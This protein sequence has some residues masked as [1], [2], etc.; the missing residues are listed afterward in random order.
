MLNQK[1]LE[2]IKKETEEFFEK[3]N[4]EVE[5]QLLPQENETVFVDVKTEEP[6]ILIGEG[7]QTLNEIQHLFKSILRKKIIDPFFIDLDISNYKK[8]KADYLRE[9]ARTEA[10]E[11]ALTGEKNYWRRCR[12]M[13]EE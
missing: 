7:G 4:F 2:K 12:L 5:I 13:K 11:A 10:D 8:K 9:M 3:M 6:Q 1:D